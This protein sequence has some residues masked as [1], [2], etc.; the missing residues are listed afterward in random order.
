MSMVGPDF[1]DHLER[2][3]ALQSN[4]RLA[5]IV[6]EGI[7]VT[8]PHEQGGTAT[9]MPT[10]RQMQE[11]YIAARE[12]ERRAGGVP[13]PIPHDPEWMDI[14]EYHIAV[15]QDRQMKSSVPLS[16]KRPANVRKEPQKL[17]TP[18]WWDKPAAVSVADRHALADITEVAI[19]EI[20]DD[21][22]LEELEALILAGM[23][24]RIEDFWHI[25][26]PSELEQAHAA[27]RTLLEKANEHDRD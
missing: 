8:L 14:P 6:R 7:S 22:T 3:M 9:R 2:Q 27:L 19:V 15:E 16:E 10:E 11:A 21:L 13:E 18:E 12:L 23:P 4:D 20:P 17:P 1:F 5:E 26:T 24:R 25:P